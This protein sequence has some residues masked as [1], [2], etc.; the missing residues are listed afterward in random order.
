VG[1]K[2]VFAGPESLPADFGAQPGEIYPVYHVFHA[3]AGAT[4]LLGAGRS[5]EFAWLCFC[6]GESE[7]WR[8]GGQLATR[9]Q[10]TGV[11]GAPR[12]YIGWGYGRASATRSG[13]QAEYFFAPE[14]PLRSDAAH[15]RSLDPISALVHACAATVLAEDPSVAADFGITAFA[16]A[17]FFVTEEGRRVPQIILREEPSSLPNSIHSFLGQD[18]G[19]A[20]AAAIGEESAA[21]FRS[22]AWHEQIHEALTAARGQSPGTG[23]W[24]FLSLFLATSPAPERFNNALGELLRSASL[25]RIEEDVPTSWQMLVNLGGSPGEKIVCRPVP[26]CAAPSSPAKPL[27]QMLSSS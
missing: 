25:Q 3:L 12:R 8:L 19:V 13:P 16:D 24:L 23:H 14:E 1:W 10:S 2:G 9:D 27:P 21:P 5:V 18:R 26:A 6:A 22:V 17:G 11:A 4:K 20:L 15:P 7:D